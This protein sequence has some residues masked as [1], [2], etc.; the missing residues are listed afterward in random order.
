MFFTAERVETAHL[1][2]SCVKRPNVDGDGRLPSVSRAGA[3]VSRAERTQVLTPLASGSELQP[4]GA[5]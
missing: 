2:R 5:D 4:L 3:G 1:F